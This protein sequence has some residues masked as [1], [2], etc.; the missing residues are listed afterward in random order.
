MFVADALRPSGRTWLNLTIQTVV[1]LRPGAFAEPA[2]GIEHPGADRA[3][4]R[5]PADDLGAFEIVHARR[6]SLERIGQERLVLCPSHGRRVVGVRTVV[7]P[8]ADQPCQVLQLRTCRRRLRELG[9]ANAIQLP[10]AVLLSHGPPGTSNRSGGFRGANDTNRSFL[11]GTSG[12]TRRTDGSITSMRTPLFSANSDSHLL[13]DGLPSLEPLAGR[14][15][16]LA[17]L[18]QCAATALASPRL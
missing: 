9:L 13:L 12:D 15:D 6:R 8:L 3:C 17:R 7:D 1:L 11:D 10:L 18:A 4:R 14:A 2:V 5:V 16:P